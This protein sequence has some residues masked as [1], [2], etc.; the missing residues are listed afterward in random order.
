MSRVPLPMVT[1]GHGRRYLLTDS[2]DAGGERLPLHRGK[3]KLRAIGVLRVAD[4]YKP[5][6]I[7]RHL[8]ALTTVAGTSATFTPPS[9]RFHALTAI[10]G[11]VTALPPRGVGQIDVVSGHPPSPLVRSGAGGLG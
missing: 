5:T 7:R 10:A 8:D 11:A 6:A 1:H 9:G 4:R 3:Q 2:L